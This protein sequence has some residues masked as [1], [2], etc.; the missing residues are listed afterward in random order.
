[1]RTILAF[2][3]I[4]YLE[5]EPITKASLRYVLCRVAFLMVMAPTA[6]SEDVTDQC[7]LYYD[8]PSAPNLVL[9]LGPH[10]KTDWEER[11]PIGNGYGWQS[12]ALGRVEPL[13]VK[14]RDLA[15]QV[16]TVL[17]LTNSR[18]HAKV[19]SESY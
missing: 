4:L 11:S 8:P 13:R 9:I 19:I 12:S 15:E 16:V 2:T 5:V 14:W 17:G 6:F 1:M 7:V 10:I 3:P 18:S